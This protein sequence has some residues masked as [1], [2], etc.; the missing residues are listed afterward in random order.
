[1]SHRPPLRR[2]VALLLVAV[3][4]LAVAACGGGDGGSQDAGSLVRQ[5]FGAD[6]PLRSG[7]IDATVNVDLQ[8][9][10]KWTEPLSLHLAGPFQT[11]GGKMVPDF[12]LDLDLQSGQQPMTVGAIFAKGAG[13]LTI[14]GRAFALGKDFSKTFQDGYLK[15]K[16]DAKAQGGDQTTLAALGI[17]PERW[18]QDP[19]DEGTEDI[20]GTE[21]DHVSSGVA[22]SRLL[23]DLSTMLGRARGVTAGAAAGR[24]PTRLTA[25]QRQA[26]ERSVKS[27][28]VDLWTGRED[29]TLR[30]FT[31]DVRIAVPADL[32]ARAGGLRSGHIGL[33]VTFAQLN[34]HQTV[35]PP[36]DARPVAELSAALQQLGLAGGTGGSG[37]SAS[38]SSASGSSAS[39]SSGSSGASSSTTPAPTGAQADYAKCLGAAGEDLAKVQRCASLLP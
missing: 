21:T 26:I 34:Q 39:D 8:G 32:Q 9:L 28:K 27:A 7:R 23:Q 29:R 35:R 10:P 30:R 11:N 19:K 12:A 20:A 14:E 13:Y 18:L 4:A 22:V 17:D 24:V 31:L 2:L 5:T 1:M 37:S 38:G 15:A 3:T 33:D 6:H 25:E 16:R 36:S